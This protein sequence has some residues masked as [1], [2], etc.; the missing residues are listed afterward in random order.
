MWGILF[1]GVFVILPLSSRMLAAPTL[2]QEDQPVSGAGGWEYRILSSPLAY[3]IP[4]RP[5]HAT[6]V[7]NGRPTVPPPVPTLED[8]IN[9]LADQGFVVD[10]FKIVGGADS[11]GYVNEF[12]SV[13]V[14]VLKR[15]KSNEQKP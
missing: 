13:V 9:K 11:N 10:T 3:A 2:R 5:D 1:T 15:P 14:V 7:L 8:K 6:T 12:S 4:F